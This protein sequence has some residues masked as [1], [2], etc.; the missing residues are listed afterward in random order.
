MEKSNNELIN[1]VLEGNTNANEAK[2][3]VKTDFDKVLY[4]Y[5]FG[6]NTEKFDVKFS[7]ETEFENLL[8]KYVPYSGKSDTIIGEIIRGYNKLMYRW[9]NDGDDIE[10]GPYSGIIFGLKC[11]LESPF[12][13]E[14]NTCYWSSYEYEPVNKYW[15]CVDRNI[16]INICLNCLILDTFDY[17][18]RQNHTDIKKYYNNIIN[19]IVDEKLINKFKEYDI[20][21]THNMG[22]YGFDFNGN[23]NHINSISEDLYVFF[24]YKTIKIEFIPLMQVKFKIEFDK[25]EIDTIL[26]MYGNLLKFIIHKAT[27]EWK[28]YPN[29]EKW[30]EELKPLGFTINEEKYIV[31]TI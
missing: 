25:N 24:N 8:N 12:V 31:K 10:C 22:S 21:I 23:I 28:K 7:V 17:Y 30:N 15:G 13:P 16:I 18:H 9:L 19:F 29:I 1:F 20:N 11:E 4:N 14:D 3:L 2:K 27:C 6:R 5:A 26:K